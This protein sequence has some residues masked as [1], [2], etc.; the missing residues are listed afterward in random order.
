[1]G[2]PMSTTNRH[3]H[4]VRAFTLLESMIASVVLA[5]GVVAITAAVI[6]SNQS[7]AVVDQASAALDVARA[8]MELLAAQPLANITS[9]SGG[10]TQTIDLPDLGNDTATTTATATFVSRSSQQGERD[11]AVVKVEVRMPDGNVCTLYRVVTK[12]GNG[13]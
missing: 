11:I 7:N 12:E 2:F 9:P 6:T 4:R 13:Q 8:D 10:V 1:M 5:F 3:I